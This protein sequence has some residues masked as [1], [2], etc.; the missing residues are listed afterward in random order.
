M[1]LSLEVVVDSSAAQSTVSRVGLGKTKHVEVKWL[2]V[3]EAVARRRLA[4][5]WIPGE[6][7]PADV[8]T[9][10]HAVDRFESMLEPSGFRIGSR[11]VFMPAFSSH[12]TVRPRWADWSE[13]DVD[14]S[15]F[16]F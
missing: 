3:Q 12:G 2:W 16:M 11:E 9:K 6:Q 15:E 10:P 1:K 5:S 13:D 7:N 8:L 4:V 14:F